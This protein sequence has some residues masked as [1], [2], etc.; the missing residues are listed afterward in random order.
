M[1][2]VIYKKS[3]V[4]ALT[5]SADSSSAWSHEVG[6]EN[7]VTLNFVTWEFVQFDAGAYIE[8]AG[9]V[10]RLKREYRPRHVN[11]SCYSYSMSFYGREHDAEDLLFCRLNQGEEDMESVFQYEG[12]PAELLAKVVENLNRNSEGFVWEPGEAVVAN[13]KSLNFNGV[14]CWDALGQ[15]AQAFGTEWWRD[16]N[17]LNLTKCERGV[18][19]ELGYGRGLSRG[20]EQREAE[21]A[22]NFFTRLIPVGSTRNIDK[23]VYG[24]ERLQLPGREKYVDVNSEL[25]LKEHREEA[26]FAEIY[27]HRVGTVTQVTMELKSNSDTGDY[28]VYSFADS[29]LPF[30]PDECMLPNLPIKVTFKTGDLADKEFDVVWH[31]GTG[32]FEIINVYRDDGS[33]QP[34]GALVPAKGDEYVLW[35][36]AMPKEYYS[37][38]EEEFKQAV[39][40]FIEESEKDASVYTAPTDYIDLGKRGISLSVG[41]RV[42]LVSTRYFPTGAHSSRITK[43][44][45]KLERLDDATIEC[46]SAV[47]KSWKSSVDN[48][49]NSISYSL[50]KEF[51]QVMIEVL[52]SGDNGTPAE[53]NVFSAL[54]SLRTF[55]RKDKEDA[56]NFFVRFLAGL[57]AGAA[58][59][60]ADGS[61]LLKRLNVEGRAAFGDD[62][63]SEEFVSG[64]TGGK[65]WAIQEKKRKNVAGEEERYS[66]AEVD[67]LVV[68]RSMKIFELVVSQL[69]G[70]NDNRVF[71]GMMEV[72]S[73]N[74]AENRVY[75]N[76]QSGKLYNPFRVNDVLL[77]QRYSG[78]EVVKMYELVVSAVGIGNV[79]D[80]EERQDWLMFSAFTGGDPSALIAKGD[81]LVRMD[82]LTD[83][84]R[85][86]IVQVTSVGANA[87][88]IDVL[89][90]WKTSPDNAL[91]ARLG[92]LDGIYDKDFGENQPEG[93]GLFA[94]NAF[95]KG[96]F[97]LNSGKDVETEFIVQEGLVKSSV[98]SL[99]G[100]ALRGRS[101]VFNP[102][103]TEGLKGWQTGNEDSIYLL[104]G[105]PV[106]WGDSVLKSSV[107]VVAAADY[108]EAKYYASIEGSAIV[109]KNVF[110]NNIESMDRDKCIDLTFAMNYRCRTS[111]MVV[112]SLEN[113]DVAAMNAC[114]GVWS[115]GGVAV[116]GTLEVVTSWGEGL[117]FQTIDAAVETGD[118][119]IVTKGYRVINVTKGLEVKYVSFV[120]FEPETV[121]IFVGINL[122]AAEVLPVRQTF[123]E[124]VAY[125]RWNG[126]GDL[127]IAYGGVIE[128]YGIRLSS[129]PTEVKYA[130]LFEQSERLIR[131]AA[132]NFNDD[133]SVK[134][135]SEII[136]KP[137]TAGLLTKDEAGNVAAMGTYEDGVVKLTGKEIRLEGEVTANGNVTFDSKGRI[138]AKDGTFSGTVT[139]S[140]GMIGKFSIGEGLE[141]NEEGTDYH[142]R[143]DRDGVD[144]GGNAGYLGLTDRRKRVVVNG[145]FKDEKDATA[146]SV[147][148]TL[149]TNVDFSTG[150]Y[151]ALVE[152]EDNS[153]YP[154]VALRVKGG[155][156][157]EGGFLHL[158]SSLNMVS[159]ATKYVLRITTGTRWLVKNDTGGAAYVYLPKL[160]DVL[161]MMSAKN[162]DDNEESDRSFA[163]PMSVTCLRGSAE[164]KLAFQTTDGVSES[165][166]G[167]VNWNGSTNVELSNQLTAGDTWEFVLI[168]DTTSGYYAQIINHNA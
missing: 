127:S 102:S 87:P 157:H 32:L 67:E 93:T 51:E 10:F 124:F 131:L 167:F 45:R 14:F 79:A 41:Q 20:L 16:G 9:E 29:E 151:P 98:Q 36:I 97:V 154:T 128:L 158:Y 118:V 18:A 30:D 146:L 120:S 107:K 71:S 12:T 138:K 43:V 70:E 140:G 160:A 42:S 144:V 86:G 150:E 119:L 145:R 100:D 63:S 135:E 130:T 48:S 13:R 142:A 37:A 123:E 164:F 82:N 134:T 148:R 112:V 22:V 62:V 40:R 66:L 153:T 114:K 49:L 143:V 2:V 46:R 54:R 52:Q 33:Q 59:L 80:G 92:N 126:S 122:L 26:A 132:K 113:C 96:K 95:L 152:I 11:N 89:R 69:L 1:E 7:V 35:N 108:A 137:G 60:D 68:R 76:T 141:Y 156:L 25:G 147:S 121:S 111:S 39:E 116:N 133:G 149:P 57:Q 75:L 23:R 83:D 110:F 61:A 94:N 90:G 47:V 77:V 103:F 155:I 55:L 101:V 78:E 139:A 159:A 8:V 104:D 58:R 161:A 115:G 19:V 28:T 72:E 125:G 56:T 5:A 105:M 24:F 129:E 4:P 165:E 50:A 84:A 21:N 168:Y 81:T 27:P 166:L 162:K 109:Q 53:Y 38:A 15:I 73:F 34:G 6:V 17:K 3:G 85:K 74:V 91:K 136:I 44:V 64:M 99:Q 106:F 163:L 88:Y 117:Q 31:A 65:G